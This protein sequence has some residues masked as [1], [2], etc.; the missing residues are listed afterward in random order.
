[1]EH[2][3]KKFLLMVVFAICTITSSSFAQLPPLIDRETFFGDPEISG[4]QISPD[5]NYITFL[6]QF[7]KVRNIW[8]KERDQEF[9]DAKPITADTAR[10]VTAYFWS[11]DSKYIL[12]VQDKGGDENYRVYAVDPSVS[13]DPVPP[14]R[15]LTPIENVRAYIYNVPKKTPNEIIIGL[16][17][18]NPQLHDVYRLNIDTGERTLIRQNNENVAVWIFDQDVQLRLALRQTT[19]GGTEILKVNGDSLIQIYYVNNQESASPYYFLPDGNTFYLIT[20]KGEKTDKIQF[21]LFDLKTGKTKLV[22][23]DPLNEVDFGGA[24]ISDKTH[25]ILATFYIGEK[26]RM[27]P[28]QKEFTR[29][30]KKLEKLLPAG[31]IS[32]TSM[33]ED[34]MT[35]LVSV[36]R[37]VDPGSVYIYDR[38]ENKAELLYKSR[39]KL[40][41]EYLASMKPIKYK[42]R[43]GMTIYGYLTL[44][45]GIPPKNLPTV[46]YVHGGPWARDFWGYNSIAQFLANRGYAVFQANFRGSAGF[47]KKYLNAGN[48]QW[49]TGSMQHDLTDAVKSLIKEGITDPRRVAI[50]GGSYGGY[51]TLAG[52]TF[53]PDIYACGFDIVGPSNIVT[54]LN[55]IP[56]YWAPIKKIFDVRVG[57]QNDPEDRKRLEEQS[58]LNYATNIKAPLFVVQGANDPRVKKAESD[59]IV[60]AL[61]DLGREVEYMC[62]PDEGHGF[63]GEMNR[64]AMF[65]A[66]EKF[67]VKHLK[68]RVQEDVR[69][70]IQNKLNEITVDINTVTMPK[71]EA[72]KESTDMLESFD[73]SKLTVTSS[74]Y[75]MKIDMRGQKINMD[76]TQKISKTS[77][78][79]KDI[80][81]IVD[82]V[83]GTMSG[84]D[85]LD[86][87]AKT[88]LP[89]RR[90]ASQMGGTVHMNFTP[91]GVEGKIKM[92]TQEMP[93]KAEISTPMLLDGSGTSIPLSTIKFEKDYKAS[94][95]QFDMMGAKAKRMNLEVADLEKIK[96]NSG[97]FETF[98]VDIINAED[99]EIVSSYWY[100]KNNRTLVK[101][102]TKIPAM[103]GGGTIVMELV[104]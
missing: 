22:E 13:G 14:A 55:S 52:L 90:S 39:P 88:L 57:D 78:D 68:G 33:T 92:G 66:M 36:S 35:W 15:D 56:P 73:S 58:P 34:E 89:I 85:T 82:E 4:A 7:N 64:L 63:A 40:P 49:G 101:S 47:G 21:E 97:E 26:R 71:R 77:L 9:E 6:K 32:I 8:V 42:A 62:A 102:E 80:W 38:K 72:P 11:H 46:L 18:R 99:N 10:P 60:V 48:K 3:M 51:A 29:D 54:L 75:V 41:T 69:Q 65:T 81:R 70:E 104:K 76:I 1:M 91:K 24:L 30:W 84:T 59:Q 61:R 44:P 19:D 86:L 93:I 98:K 31:D 45:K 28:R 74:K 16:N 87:D 83:S 67:F 94:F 95:H 100:D 12:Y 5:G 37:D 103:M 43:D 17:D 25:E 50:S 27:Y 2:N 23:K 96:I 20:N 79:G 53:T